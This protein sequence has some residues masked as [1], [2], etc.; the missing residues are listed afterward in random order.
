MKL[1]LKSRELFWSQSDKDRNFYE[2]V[3]EKEIIGSL[4][5]KKQFSPK[6][7]AE[8]KKKNWIFRSIGF[9]KPRVV[10]RA[11]KKDENIA[12]FEP[13]RNGEGNLFFDKEN[14]F[15]WK[16]ADLSYNEFAFF[17]KESDN[18]IIK[19]RKVRSKKSSE[20]FNFVSE[21]DIQESIELDSQTI[22]LVFFGWFLFR[23]YQNDEAIT[24]A[25]D[26]SIL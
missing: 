11:E 7:T 8:C 6:A 9:F 5:W 25:K 4:R 24:A 13:K 17:D 22:L 16:P 3:C 14:Y 10:I 12:I 21:I 19:I 18:F 2:L 1:K 20:V 26:G 15:Y 23:S